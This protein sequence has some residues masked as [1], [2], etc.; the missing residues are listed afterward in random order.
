MKK[1]LFS[2]ISALFIVAGS[3]FAAANDVDFVKVEGSGGSVGYYSDLQEAFNSVS[4]GDTVTLLKDYTFNYTGKSITG[5]DFP[6]VKFTFDGGGFTIT[7]AFDRKLHGNHDD[8]GSYK[9][10]GGDV[11]VKNVTFR[12]DNAIT[13]EDQGHTNGCFLVTNGTVRFNNVTITHYYGHNGSAFWGQG[14][15]KIIIEDKVTVSDCHAKTR[16][17]IGLYF[18]DAEI[19]GLTVDGGTGDAIVA[20]PV[21]AKVELKLSDTSISGVTGSGIVAGGTKS[22]EKTTVVN[23][24]GGIKITNC[25]G[26][27]IHINPGA[28]VKVRGEADLSGNKGGNIKITGSGILDADPPIIAE[29]EKIVAGEISKAGWTVSATS[30]FVKNPAKYLIDNDTKTFW[31]SKYDEIDGKAK[32]I[33][34]APYTLDFTLPEVTDISGFALLSR[35]DSNSGD[36]KSY[37][38]LVSDSDDG[39]FYAVAKD[40]TVPSYMYEAKGYTKVINLVA[41]V[42]AKRIRLYIKEGSVAAFAEFSVIKGDDGKETMTPASYLEYA[43]QN[44]PQL[45]PSDKFKVSCE[46]EAWMQFT[47]VKA[48][49]GTNQSMWQTEAVGS[50]PVNISIDLGEVYEI[51]EIHYLPR[52][53]EDKHGLWLKANI[54]YST[55][56]TVYEKIE[57]YTFKENLDEKIISFGEGCKMRYVEIEVTEYVANRVSASE[58]SFYETGKGHRERIEENK[59]TY[60]LTIGSDAIKIAKGKNNEISEKKIDV[61][62]YIVNGSTFIPLRGLLEEMGAEISWDGE[63]QLIT[64]KNNALTIELQIWNNTVWVTNSKVDGRMMYSVPNPPVISDNRTF[65]PVR[66][67]SEI[68]GYTVSWDGTAQTV[69]IKN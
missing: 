12:M 18:L 1:R 14:N 65:V 5:I 11:T 8:R 66:F 48:F 25:E 22:E 61:A 23:I 60:T 31:H 56:K 38:I 19:N 58:I 29:G 67:L 13:S 63:R 21:G 39:E 30:E 47:I 20:G 36:L 28:Q 27:G 44:T 69:T 46:E 55:D 33:E 49:D 59:T 3:V 37:D 2:L 64:V 16:G 50:R 26:S 6:E 24:S 32:N 7:D 15:G 34:P 40:I 9:I 41:N 51:E 68:L 54:S 57:N 17:I 43:S 62:P 53:T 10:S 45:I 52:L 35:K 4:E 42:N